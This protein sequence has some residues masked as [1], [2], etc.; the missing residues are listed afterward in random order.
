MIYKTIQKCVCQVSSAKEIYIYITVAPTQT[1]LDKQHKIVCILP[2]NP[3][4][5]HHPPPSKRHP[6]RWDLHHAPL[7]G[8]FFHVQNSP[9]CF[10][11]S[12]ATQNSEKGDILRLFLYKGLIT[13]LAPVLNLL[14][15]WRRYF[16]RQIWVWF[17]S[18]WWSHHPIGNAV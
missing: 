16:G 1:I 9:N 7:G 18:T 6:H 5:N 2:S 17:H 3:N 8:V 4:L 13:S 10:R 11:H 12:M 15:H 14:Y